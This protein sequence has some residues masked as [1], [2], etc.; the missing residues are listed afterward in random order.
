MFIYLY[1]YMYMYIYMYLYM[2]INIS[3]TIRIVERKTIWRHIGEACLDVFPK[4]KSIWRQPGDNFGDTIGI[5]L[6]E[7]WPPRRPDP[8]R[9]I[10]IK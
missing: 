4:T 1:I 3:K 5:F 7:K 6:E 8:V 2:Y 9:F 10:N